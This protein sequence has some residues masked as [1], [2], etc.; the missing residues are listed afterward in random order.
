[1]KGKIK[2][3]TSNLEPSSNRLIKSFSRRIEVMSEYNADVCWTIIQF[4][5]VLGF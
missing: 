1:M 3:R 4:S 5:D 2:L